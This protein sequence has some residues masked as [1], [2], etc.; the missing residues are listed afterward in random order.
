MPDYQEP[1]VLHEEAE[2]Q[3]EDMFDYL[4]ATPQNKPQQSTEQLKFNMV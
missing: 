2:H 3:I 4:S 1:I